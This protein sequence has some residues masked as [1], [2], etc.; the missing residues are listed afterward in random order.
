M[1]SR[2][3]FVALA[4]VGGLASFSGETQ[5]HP[6]PQGEVI[7]IMGVALAALHVSEAALEA[8][9]QRFRDPKL[10]LRFIKEALKRAAKELRR[11]ARHDP[12]NRRRLKQQA[13]RLDRARR[14]LKLAH[15]QSV[16]QQLAAVKEVAGVRKEVESH[17]SS[18]AVAGGY[19]HA[20]DDLLGADGNTLA[21]WIKA[22]G[23]LTLMGSNPLIRDDK[24]IG[25]GGLI[26][27][28]AGSLQRTKARTTASRLSA[29]RLRWAKSKNA[30]RRRDVLREAARANKA[31]LERL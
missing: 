3:G 21:P 29:A 2:R 13:K 18:G 23:P 7:R 12:V 15:I 31:A 5:A 20:V 26:A 22:V 19:A 6:Q 24:L 9:W 8:Q 28:A 27:R 30:K 4:A 10:L 17:T 1:L 14:R 16:A 11:A 25:R